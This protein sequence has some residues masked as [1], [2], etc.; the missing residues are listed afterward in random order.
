M[1]QGASSPAYQQ[2]TKF[3]GFSLAAEYVFTLK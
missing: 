2:E 1:V 3:H